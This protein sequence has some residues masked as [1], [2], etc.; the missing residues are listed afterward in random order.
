MNKLFKIVS[1]FELILIIILVCS[2]S[3]QYKKYNSIK[4]GL[5]DLF[6]I[7]KCIKI[8]DEPTQYITDRTN[9]SEFFF[10]RG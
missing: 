2:A 1:F 10:E 5:D 3:L 9:A 7:K 6:E 4:Y 8:N